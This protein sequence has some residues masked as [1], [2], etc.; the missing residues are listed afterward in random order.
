V[1]F[2]AGDGVLGSEL[3]QSNG[4]SAGTFLVRDISPGKGGSNPSYLTPVNGALFFQANDGSHGTELWMTDGTAGGTSLVRDIN[5]GSGGSSPGPMLNMA[6]R[7]FFAANDGVHGAEPWVLGPV[8]LSSFANVSVVG[9]DSGLSGSP[10][11]L[12]PSEAKKATN[13]SPLLLQP[14]SATD[15]NTARGVTPHI[16]LATSSSARRAVSIAELDE[17]IASIFSPMDK[18]ALG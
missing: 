14:T 3:W 11:P 8:P 18:G 9:T 16:P 13:G 10:N 12:A 6:G 15:P 4:T 5:P 2:R 1:F 7:L 17:A